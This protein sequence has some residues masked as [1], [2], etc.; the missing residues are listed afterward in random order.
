M[1][2][3]KN[4]DTKQRGAK[5]VLLGDDQP[6]KTLYLARCGRGKTKIKKAD[7]DT[8]RHNGTDIARLP[9]LAAGAPRKVGRVDFELEFVDHLSGRQPVDAPR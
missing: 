1:G 5:S 3:R 4:R 6:Q 2:R 9:V 8:H 7:A